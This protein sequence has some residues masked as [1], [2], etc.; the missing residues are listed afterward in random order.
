LH[1]CAACIEHVCTR[2]IMPITIKDIARQAGVSHPTVSRALR[3]DPVV[4]AETMLRIQRIA[5]TLGYIPSATARSLKS[6]QSHV[7]GVIVNRISDP[8]YS[9]VLDGIQDVLFSAGYSLFLAAT[10][11]NPDREKA[12]VRAM[13]ER[14]VDGLIVCSVWATRRFLAYFTANNAPVVVVHNRSNNKAPSS[15]EHDDR[16]GGQEMTRHLIELGHTRLAF[17]GNARAGRETEERLKGF[18]DAMRVARLT[19]P[20]EYVVQ[21]AKGQMAKGREAVRPL[22]ELPDPPTALVCFNDMLAV[23]AMQMLREK[24]R[25]VPDDCSVVGFDDIPLS[26]LVTPALTTFDQP[27]YPL[28]EEAARMILRLLDGKSGRGAN[29]KPGAITL[30][31][32]IRVRASTAPPPRP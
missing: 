25:R 17:A 22:L 16:F 14:R 19:V 10:D 23:G 6:S 11:H 4:A 8:F 7:L 3:D 20:P 29:S 28:G 24:G 32:K 18:H 5:S 30:R 1:T 2:K 31:G 15:V 9:E 21:A 27:K 13:T 26:A 12:I